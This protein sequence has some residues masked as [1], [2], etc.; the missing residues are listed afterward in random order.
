MS[1]VDLDENELIGAVQDEETA[2]YKVPT[3]PVL[4]STIIARG[5]MDP[6]YWVLTI[7]MDRYHFIILS[8]VKYHWK[9]LNNHRVAWL[10]D[11]K[12]SWNHW[13]HSIVSS[14]VIYH[15][16]HWRTIE[17]NGTWTKTIVLKPLNTKV[18]DWLSE[19]Q[20]SWPIDR[21]QTHLGPMKI[22]F[23]GV[24]AFAIKSSQK[25]KYQYRDCWATN[26]VCFCFQINIMSNSRLCGKW[27]PACFYFWSN[28]FCAGSVWP[29]WLEP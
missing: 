29:V 2:F 27:F 7:A 18:S 26:Y 6:D 1:E 11:Q 13:D 17:H 24:I 19:W 12:P 28:L 25:P 9:P 20:S 10:W 5:T 23:W 22:I 3:H 14:M 8:M 16:N 4:N 21:P 15:K